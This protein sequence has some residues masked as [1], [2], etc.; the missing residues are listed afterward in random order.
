[1][2]MLANM[3]LA[4][5]LVVGFAVLLLTM[6]ATGAVTFA[7]VRDVSAHARHAR[8]ESAVFAGIA[9]DMKRDAIQ[10]Q[11]WLSDISATRG[12]DGLADG[13]D[14]ANEARTSFLKGLARF[15]EMYRR[16]NDAE[17]LQKLDQLERKLGAYHALGTTMAQ[18]YIAEGPA[19]GNKH[20]A[21]FDKAAEELAGALDPFVEEQV[22]ELNAAMESIV[23]SSDRLSTITQ[24]AA[25]LGAVFGVLCAWLVTRSI[26]APMHT[27]VAAMNDIAEGEGDLTAR[28]DDSS[29]DEIGQMAAA[30]NRF[31]GSI[32]DVIRRSITAAQH[33]ASAAQQ[34]S[35]ASE[36]L[37][38]GTHEQAS[39][40]EETAASLE[41]ITGTVKQNADNARHA[42]EL[43]AGSHD[44]ASKGGR[45][46]AEAVAAMAGISQHSGKM[47]DITATIDEIAFQTNLLALNAAVEAARAGDQGR[48]F[49]VVATEVRNLA[50]RSASAAR[51]IRT[52]IQDSVGKVEAGSRLVNASGDTLG[53]IVGSVS[54]VT[55]IMAEIAAASTQQSSGIEQVNS[56]ITQMDQVVQGNSAQTEELSST[57]QSLA[58][59]AQE[60]QSLVGRFK[61]AGGV[62][63]A[64]QP[65]PALPPTPAPSAGTRRAVATPVRPPAPS[66]PGRAPAHAVHG[67][68]NGAGRA[69]PDG[70]DEF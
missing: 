9:R 49:A 58:T 19:A 2:R 21:A 51:E 56:A 8:E 33:V 37:S 14:K 48:G 38:T 61:V 40:L 57:A 4:Y 52:L 36:Q 25:L 41:E 16:E 1:M 35:A 46:V 45:V 63:H 29:R 60:L 64:N 54:R 12:L 50:Q 6:I 27:A 17:R 44:T 65:A 26:T 28:L 3:R 31:V 34:L 24:L 53:E 69:T 30:F 15:R 13:F 32:E 7:V 39:A 55:G 68:S 22:E 47:A 20:M 23:R 62:A 59:Q 18:A 43:V 42:S 10:I 70:F 66:T 11:Q 5:R 67:A